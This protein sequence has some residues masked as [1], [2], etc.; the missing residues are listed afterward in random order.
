VD[1]LH[2]DRTTG[3]TTIFAY[4]VRE[5]WRKKLDE[6]CSKISTHQHEC[7]R[8]AFLSTAAFTASARDEAIKH[9]NSNY[10]W[11]LD[12]F[13][14]ERIRVILAANT[15]LLSR[16]SSIFCQP[17]FPAAGGLA[18]SRSLDHAIVDHVDADAALAQWITRRLTLLGYSIWCRGLA[19]LAGSHLLNTIRTL[20]RQRA[21]I[22]LPV[23]STS[24]TT[25]TD[26][27]SRLLFAN[28]LSTE[29]SHPFV[30]PLFHSHFPKDRLDSETR[31]LQAAIFTDNWA[32]GMRSVEKALDA[33]HC[34]R[35]QGLSN[36]PYLP[37]SP[38][39]AESEELFSNLFRM[40]RIPPV[41]HRYRSDTP[42]PESSELLLESWGVRAVGPTSFLSFHRPPF[43]LVCD[44]GMKNVGGTLWTSFPEVEGIRCE[45]LL[46]ELIRKSLYAECLRRGLAKNRHDR[47]IHF[48]E[49]LIPSNH[50]KFTSYD[51]TKTFFDVVG[52]RTHGFGDRAKKFRYHLSPVF[53]PKMANA[54]HGQIIVR[55]RLYLTGLDGVPFPGRTGDSRRKKLCRSWWNDAWLKRTMGVMQFLSDDGQTIGIGGDE[56]DRLIVKALPSTWSAPVRLDEGVLRDPV[57]LDENEMPNGQ[58]DQIDDEYEDDDHAK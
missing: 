52:E 12:L 21:F 35:S 46:V 1:T 32:T 17:F 40:L 51:G 3:E 37:E 56:D 34:P 18:L 39:L 6:D 42:L 28:S 26:Y 11:D 33:A 49:G 27:T 15:S 16:H 55:I 5:D 50:L 7:A 57:E 31:Q 30:L 20:L 2:V 41:I 44:V 9:V 54:T 47:G 48:P 45:D 8:I 36:L 53:V 23:L 29:H 13:G 14:L 4:S 22:Y 24:S 19:P 58:F 43:E 25:D 10:G 38:I